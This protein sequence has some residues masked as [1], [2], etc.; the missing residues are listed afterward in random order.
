MNSCLSG[1]TCDGVDAELMLILYSTANLP[2]YFTLFLHI[3]K[4]DSFYNHYVCL[5]FGNILQ[6]VDKRC[7]I[8]CLGIKDHSV[9]MVGWL[10]L[11]LAGASYFLFTG[12]TGRYYVQVIKITKRYSNRIL[13]CDIYKLEIALYSP[14]LKHSFLEQIFCTCAGTY[15]SYFKLRKH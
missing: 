8:F 5:V 13:L 4:K 10:E 1:T 9:I 7:I 11:N 12:M 2:W 3:Q 15:E 14:W 6:K